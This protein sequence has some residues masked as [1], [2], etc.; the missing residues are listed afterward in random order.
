VAQQHGGPSTAEN[1]ALACGYCN[2][3]K[4]PNIA[5]LDPHTGA[6]VPLYDPRRDQWSDHF[7]WDNTLVVGKT[8]IARATLELLGVNHWQ[9]I[10]LRENLQ[11]LGE[12]FAD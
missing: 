1:L 12:R 6:L 10:E 7:A 3:H 2:L 11:S 8:P 5:S 4:G 9:R